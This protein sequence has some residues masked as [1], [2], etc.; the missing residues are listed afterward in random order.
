VIGSASVVDDRV[1]V[2]TRGGPVIALDATNGK[3]IWTYNLS[4]RAS[5]AV[6]QRIVLIGGE[7]GGLHALAFD[8]G[9]PI[10]LF[11]TGSPIVSS[12]VVVGD[13]VFIASGLNLYAIDLHTGTGL[14]RFSTTDTIEASPAIANETIYI[15]SRDGFLYA[16][17]GSDGTTPAD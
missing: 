10:W 2:S 1:I 3:T 6:S 8:D 4:G 15:G 5:V 17:G 7:D 16:I 14:W 12:P 11:P 13:Q 9:S